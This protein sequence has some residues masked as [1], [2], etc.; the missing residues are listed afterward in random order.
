M[1]GQ[2]TQWKRV[3]PDVD[4]LLGVAGK[5]NAPRLALPGNRDVLEARLQQ[6]QHFVA[7]DIGSDDQ[8]PRA[9]PVE[10][11]V[12]VCAQPEEVVAL[13]GRDQLEGRML[14]AVPVDDLGAG[15]ELLAPRAVQPLVLGFEQVG[16]MPLPDALE[17]CRD[18]A[19]VPRLRGANP[20]VVR[21][22]E[23]APVL[24]E[25]SGHAVDPRMRRDA[26]A[27]GRLDHRLAVLV[28]PHQEMDVVPAQ[29]V[30]AGD[31]VRADL[32]ERV[33]EMRLAIRVVDRRRE[34]ELGGRHPSR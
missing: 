34:I 14:H 30:I 21:A 15:L 22:A 6:A 28:H 5:R 7:A 16:G 26:G 31:A 29:P 24:G 20:V 33:P 18:R 12:A 17:Q 25:C 3:E 9:D 19:R 23:A 13:F 4:G 27:R 10:D 1:A 8:R 2:I 11:R 32:L